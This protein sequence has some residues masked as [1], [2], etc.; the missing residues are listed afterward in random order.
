MWTRHLYRMELLETEIETETRANNPYG[1][2]SD[3]II[4]HDSVTN[5][6]V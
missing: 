2:V 4:F 6:G 3:I 5:S 1:W